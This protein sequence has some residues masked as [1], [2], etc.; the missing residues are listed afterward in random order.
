MLMSVNL[1][2][3]KLEAHAQMASISTLVI[4]QMA[5]L[6]TTVRIVSTSVCH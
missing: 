1:T 5:I 6:E 4:V 2:P 3:A